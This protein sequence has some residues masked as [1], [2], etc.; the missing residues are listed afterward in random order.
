MSNIDD[1]DRQELQQL[2]IKLENEHA[3]LDQE[4]ALQMTTPG[5]DQI[6]I[7]RL[8]RRKLRLKDMIVK[9]KS[10]VMPDVPA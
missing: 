5:I 4:V 6:S 9:L 10:G 3:E 1:I 2:L 7:S 8:K